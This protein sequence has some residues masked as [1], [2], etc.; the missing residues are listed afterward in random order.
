MYTVWPCDVVDE[1]NS[2]QF[3]A[4]TRHGATIFPGYIHIN[5]QDI[6]LALKAKSRGRWSG[7]FQEHV[8]NIPKTAHIL[9]IVVRL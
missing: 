3:E 5:M 7:G 8:N 9:D 2:L 1:S 4:T 6:I